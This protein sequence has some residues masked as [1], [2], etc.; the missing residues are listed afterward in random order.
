[1]WNIFD[2][3]MPD[4]GEYAVFSLLS[5][6][7]PLIVPCLILI[8]VVKYIFDKGIFLSMYLSEL[9]K[10]RKEYKDRRN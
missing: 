3:D 5:L 8:P 10:M 1:M 4:C 7:W 9:N 2:D 6:F